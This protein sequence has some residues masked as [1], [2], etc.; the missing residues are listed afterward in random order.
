MCMLQAAEASCKG[1]PFR[2]DPGR[3]GRVF[4][5][6]G[7]FAAVPSIL[8]TCAS[9]G[10]FF[11]SCI[12]SRNCLRLECLYSIYYSSIAKQPLVDHDS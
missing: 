12:C 8:R 6:D 11:A 1:S 2:E 10:D 9:A 5:S 7:I 3:T 4:S